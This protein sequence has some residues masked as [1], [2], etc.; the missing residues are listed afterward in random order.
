MIKWQGTVEK[1]GW[2]KNKVK[3]CFYASSFHICDWRPNDRKKEYRLW[4]STT[5]LLFGEHLPKKWCHLS[6]NSEKQHAYG[7]CYV[8]LSTKIQNIF[9]RVT[10]KSIFYYYNKKTHISLDFSLINGH[11]YFHCHLTSLGEI[12]DIFYA[13]SNI[14]CWDRFL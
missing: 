6:A 5:G 9:A 11:L 1:K 14:R 3:F 10:E 12:W 2:M 7:F 8:N 4:E 13:R